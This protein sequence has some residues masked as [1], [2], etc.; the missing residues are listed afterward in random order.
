MVLANVFYQ[1]FAVS[2][3]RNEIFVCFLNTSFM[4]DF[5]F[6]KL[7]VQAFLKVLMGHFRMKVMGVN[8]ID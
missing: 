7:V 3:W 5:L 4:N 2:K 1:L 6:I 8:V